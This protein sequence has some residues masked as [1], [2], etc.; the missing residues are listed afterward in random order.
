M[1]LKHPTITGQSF[2]C[3]PSG[4]NLGLGTIL[5]CKTCQVHI[6]VQYVSEDLR[7]DLSVHASISSHNISNQ[8]RPSSQIIAFIC[9][10][11]LDN[12]WNVC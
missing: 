6:Y 9:S 8:V 3:V 10:P 2:D 5:L 1:E 12:V 7:R 4:L 11:N